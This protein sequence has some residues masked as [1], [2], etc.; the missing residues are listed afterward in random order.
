MKHATT[1]TLACAVVSCLFTNPLLGQFDGPEA[2]TVREREIA[3]AQ[4]M[5]N[6]DFEAFLT[7]LSPDAVFFAGDR[8]LRGVDAIGEAWRP[9]FDGD[10]PPFSWRPDQVQVIDRGGLAFSSGPVLGSAGEA[11]GRFNSIWRK[12]EDGVWRVIFDKGS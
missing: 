8:P 12:G 11:T 7:F 4:T 3:F 1:G 5:A 10:Q 9:F 6:R 2:E